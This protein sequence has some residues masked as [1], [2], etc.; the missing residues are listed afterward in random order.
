M[1]TSFKSVSAHRVLSAKGG[2]PKEEVGK[3]KKRKE[4]S[5]KER[6]KCVVGD[7]NWQL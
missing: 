1:T 2:K 4:K 3:K 5:H 6:E 7:S